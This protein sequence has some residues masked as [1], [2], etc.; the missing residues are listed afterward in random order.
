MAW[1][2]TYPILALS[3]GLFALPS[4]SVNVSSISYSK[5]D[6]RYY[7]DQD[8]KDFIRPGV[9][10]IIESAGVHED[11][12][13]T[14]TYRLVD[15]LDVPLDVN[16]IKTAGAIS[17]NYLLGVIPN[18][19]DHYQSYLIRQQ[20]S[21]ITGNTASQP[22][23]ETDGS[24]E[25]LEVGHY[26]YTFSKKLPENYDPN[27]THTIGMYVRRDLRDYELGRAVDNGVFHFLPSGGEVDRIRDVVATETCNNCHDPLAIHGGARKEVAL[28]IM[29]HYPDVTDPDTGHS[30]DMAEMV[31]KIHMG[32]DLPSVQAGTPYQ[33]I[34]FRQS[35][36][37]Y[38]NVVFPR[39]NRHCDSCH[40]EPAAQHDAW[41][42]NPT[43]RSCGSCHDDVNFAT[44]DGHANLPQISDNLCGNCHFPEGELEFDTSIVGAHTIPGESRQ[45]PGLV[46]QILE[47]TQ[48]GPGLSPTVTFRLTNYAGD[49][50]Q[51]SSL[52]FF[53][54]LIAG[55]SEDYDFLLSER[56]VENSIAEGDS[57]SYS[58]MGTL[59]ENAI[60]TFA[61]SGEAFRFQPLNAGTVLEM[62]Q[63]E[64]ARNPIHY[65]SVGNAPV[66]PRR[67]IVS[68]DKCGSCHKNLSFHGDIREG[69]EYC[70]VCHQTGA[71]DSPFRPED[72]F[73]A[74]TIDFKFMIHRIHMGDM[75]GNDYTLFGFM[76]SRANFNEVVYPGDLRNCEGCHV[77]ESYNIPSQGVA[78]TTALN[79]FF[80]PIPASSASCL[81]CHDTIDAA[82]HAFVNISPI[83][84]ACGSCHG[85][86]NR[87]SAARVHARIAE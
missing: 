50:V 59:P 64:T 51:P 5:F 71:D 13:V 6:K 17:R 74:R 18:D 79:E 24:L 8:K 15:D 60:G 12:S 9:H 41:L 23:S 10:L 87:Y 20:T 28:C 39:D 7:R 32:S 33:I 2:R 77:N 27:A 45:L 55:P 21:P 36:H 38:S 65:F 47:V 29:C 61:A 49:I 40:T 72:Q 54:L 11:R 57:F 66:E 30:V 35:V 3:I 82:A 48:I 75:L 53:N 34:G 52:P 70:V 1:I 73:P 81:G 25:T 14:V 69:S 4:A 63:R 67:Q 84:E 86:D 19:G 56:A 22:T 58:F 62:N 83:G 31:H 26:R 80:T 46:I 68:D 85:P 78:E 42:K 44:G 37:D 16:G 76:G 43:R